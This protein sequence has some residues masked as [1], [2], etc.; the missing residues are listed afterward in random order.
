MASQAI[1]IDLANN[2]DEHENLGL[3]QK[4]ILNIRRIEGKIK[5]IRGIMTNLRGSIEMPPDFSKPLS[6]ADFITP[7]CTMSSPI[8]MTSPMPDCGAQA[9]S[10]WYLAALLK[11]LNGLKTMGK[12]K[13][14]EG[15]I[16]KHKAGSSQQPEMNKSSKVEEDND[17]IEY[18][19]FPLY[20]GSG[21]PH[22]HLEAYLNELAVIGQSDGLKKKIFVSSLVGPVLMWYTKKDTSK[23]IS[24]DD[25]AID[26][27]W[28]FDNKL[29]KKHIAKTDL[30]ESQFRDKEKTIINGT[31]KPTKFEVVIPQPQLI[32]YLS[33][34]IFP[35]SNYV[36]AYY[37]QSFTKPQTIWYLPPFVAPTSNY[38]PMSYKNPPTNQQPNQSTKPQHELQKIPPK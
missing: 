33:P 30:V 20:D 23:W 1:F 36:Q 3:R 11:T 28:Q 32:W 37:P 13:K 12:E 17:R 27:I 24:W 8:S 19:N 31:S 21:N 4:F 7:T 22:S 16:S 6:E 5:R 35:S 25:L 15:Q 38:P 18:L 14:M 2:N 9:S 26:F 34:K 29:T 10:S